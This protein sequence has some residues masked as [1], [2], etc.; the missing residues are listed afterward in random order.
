MSLLPSKSPLKLTSTGLWCIMKI[1]NKLKTKQ[2]D[3]VAWCGAVDQLTVKF[4]GILTHK[5]STPVSAV[6]LAGIFPAL[7]PRKYTRLASRAPPVSTAP[8]L[9]GILQALARVIFP[10]LPSP[11]A[12]C[13]L[14][15]PPLQRSAPKVLPTP[16]DPLLFL[17]RSCFCALPAFA[18]PQSSACV[19]QVAFRL[20]VPRSVP[21]SPS[22]FPSLRFLS[23]PRPPATTVDIQP[24]DP[25]FFSLAERRTG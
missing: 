3:A 14:C 17:S 6:R 1:Q 20:F 16:L 4:S 2:N 13:P 23:S 9:V 12:F 7:M 18:R 25:L 15:L 24:G 10:L 8:K 19:L 21:F 11:V 5:I 22:S